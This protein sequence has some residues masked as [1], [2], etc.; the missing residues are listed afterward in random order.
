MERPV[1]VKELFMKDV[2]IWEYR[3]WFEKSS[4]KVESTNSPISDI[5]FPGITICSN[6]RVSKS[7]FSN[8]LF[9]QTFSNLK[10]FCFYYTQILI[11]IWGCNEDGAMGE[12][13]DKGA[14]R[15]G[16]C[17]LC[18]LLQCHLIQ[19]M[20]QNHCF[21]SAL[22]NHHKFGEIQQRAWSSLVHW[23]IDQVIWNTLSCH[24]ANSHF[25]D[26][27]NIKMGKKTYFIWSAWLN[28]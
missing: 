27:I 11:Q 20:M 12:P 14:R 4:Q 6:I 16:L 19:K 21:C 3:I 7:R 17:D 15:R 24:K 13:D 28:I 22:R 10:R 2:L 5:D 8:S 9:S 18:L 1:V 25:L 26:N 23:R